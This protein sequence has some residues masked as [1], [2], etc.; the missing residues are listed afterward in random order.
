MNQNISAFPRH[1]KVSPYQQ[2]RQQQQHTTYRRKLYSHIFTKQE[3]AMSAK[4]ASSNLVRRTLMVD[5]RPSPRLSSATSRL[6]TSPAKQIPSS[7]R[8]IQSRAVKIPTITASRAR[9]RPSLEPHQ[10]GG[11]QL[12]L[13]LPRGSRTIF[14]QTETTP[15]AD[16][17]RTKPLSR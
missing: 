5:S 8:W 3:I 9:H 16:V 17:S 14:I 13:S 12:P 1:Q 11:P 6:T 4:T 10:L 2:Q 15:N 7:S